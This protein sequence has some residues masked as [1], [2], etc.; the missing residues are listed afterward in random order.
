MEADASSL[1]TTNCDLDALIKGYS[2][3][4]SMKELLVM[5][6]TLDSEDPCMSWY[7]RVPSLSNIADLPSRGKWKELF[8]LVPLCKQIDAWCPFTSG[9]LQEFRQE[10]NDG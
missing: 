8:S 2:M 5:L 4:D 6:E 1:L 10:S 7:C 3:E 9:K